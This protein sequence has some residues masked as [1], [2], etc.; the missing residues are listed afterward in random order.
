MFQQS[1]RNFL[2]C[3]RVLPR[4]TLYLLYDGFRAE[5]MLGC[6]QPLIITHPRVEIETQVL[7]HQAQVL[8]IQIVVDPIGYYNNQ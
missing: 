7:R 5:E 2:W 3:G 1:V 8:R 4:G 6:G